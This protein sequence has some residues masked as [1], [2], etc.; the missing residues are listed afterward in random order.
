M[1]T[2]QKNWTPTVEQRVQLHNGLDTLRAARA[3]VQSCTSPHW[4]DWKHAQEQGTDGLQHSFT[5]FLSGQ[6]IPASYV[7]T[8]WIDHPPFLLRDIRFILREYSCTCEPDTFPAQSDVMAYIY[9]KGK[10]IA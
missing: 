5:F 6:D 7:F 9:S 2:K 3:E 4:Q 1:T 8:G 10:G